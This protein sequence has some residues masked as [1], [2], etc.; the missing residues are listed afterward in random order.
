LKIE[1]I[2]IHVGTPE[3]AFTPLKLLE[4]R[5]EA[6]VAFAPA[7]TVDEMN[8]KL[9]SMAAK[10]GANAVIRVEYNSGVS[11]TSWKSMKGTGLAVLRA[12]E[13]VSC[14]FCAE[15]V[16]RAAIKCKHCGANLQK[17][18]FRNGFQDEPSPETKN[19]LDGQQETIETIRETNNPQ[20]WIFASVAVLIV[21]FLIG[22]A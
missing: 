2:E 20:L 5:C 1:D 10:V 19:S 7:P 11:L 22:L 6:T 17:E 14:P 16:K 4:A 18:E 8:G 3:F 13:D 15:L 12:T 21:L 9:R